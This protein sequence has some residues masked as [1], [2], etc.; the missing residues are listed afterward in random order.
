MTWKMVGHEWAARLL[1][2]HLKN[3]Q[4]RHAYL[5]S[6]PPGIGKRTL[7]LR[8][9]QAVLCLNPPAPGEYCG[10]CRSCVTIPEFRH[11]DV[12]L[13]ETEPNE[14]SLKVDQIRDLQRKI[15]LSPYEG[16]HR[17]G[18]LSNFHMATDQAANALLKTLEEPPPQVLLV[19]TATSPETL[20]PTIVSRCEQINLRPVP[21][22]ELES[23]LID[24]GIDGEQASL[25]ARLS[26]GRPGIA[27]DLHRHADHLQERSGRA[28]EFLDLL[29]L[30]PIER[31][32][33]VEKWH[34]QLR[35]SSNSLDDQRTSCIEVL[36]LW[37][38][39]CRDILFESYGVERPLINPNQVD[40]I[41]TISFSQQSELF[42]G[43]LRAITETIHFISSNANIRLALEEL[44]LS[45]PHVPRSEATEKTA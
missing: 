43:S 32:S 7:T 1:Q 29:A 35:K 37:L 21:M 39:I 42:L 19:L 4:T 10:I 40:E 22:L 2:S 31:F 18:L 45:L 44:V 41:H 17:I 11:P 16:T 12:H 8:F 30:G 27:I 3:D 26:G 9:T 34:Q 28:E 20:L 25:L 33:F 38:G 6:G 24:T 36:E 23:G 14:R 13:V 5:I 15:S